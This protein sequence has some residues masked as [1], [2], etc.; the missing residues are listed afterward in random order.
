[1]KT[2]RYRRHIALVVI[3]PFLSAPAALSAQEHAI[4][5][6][7]E[8][9]LT[10][11]LS[12]E[13][14]SVSK[15]LEQIRDTA[16][17]VHVVT[18]DDIRR[19]GATSIPEA[20]RLV[21]GVN[22]SRINSNQWAV[23]IR[24]F[25]GR[26]N[27]KLL[28]LMDGRS[29][30]RPTFSGTYWEELD[31][32]LPDI[33]R[34]EVIRGPGATL[35][36]SNAVNGIINIITRSASDTYG[37][38]VSAGLGTTTSALLGV[39]HGL[40]LTEDTDARFYANYRDLDDFE[41][42]A[43]GASA[44]DGNDILSAGFRIDGRI[45]EYMDFTL[46]GDRYRFEATALDLFQFPPPVADLD[47]NGWNLLGRLNGA[48]STGADW[49]LQAYVART[50]RNEHFIQQIEDTVDL[51]FQYR[52]A[53]GERQDVVW[54]LGYRHIADE[55]Q[56]SQW[57]A[58]TPSTDNGDI[59]NAFI[60][61]EIELVPDKLKLILGTKI[62][63][64]HFTGT[65]LQPSV[66]VHWN[67]T[68]EHAFWSSISK[69]V[70]TP[71]RADRS[72]TASNPFSPIGVSGNST[73]ENEELMA[74]ELGY[75]FSPDSN[76]SIDVA[77]F[78]N[79]YDKL[80]STEPQLPGFDVQFANLREGRGAGGEI[81]VEWKP[82]DDLRIRMGYAYLDLD[83][84]HTAG[85]LLYG[86]GTDPT[87]SEGTPE[88]TAS[89]QLSYDID[90]QWGWDVWTLYTS[91]IGRPGLVTGT[92][93][94][95]A[96]LSLN[97]RVSWRLQPGLELSLTGENLLESRHVEYV[98]EYFTPRTEI[99]RSFMLQMRWDVE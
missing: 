20:L 35:W 30:Y 70:R 39:R 83:I 98:G 50:D 38:S 26:F 41:L 34:I 71:S 60:Q 9:S 2:F 56:Q 53:W 28:V 52:F 54:G 42:T 21:P 68:A 66:R 17:A 55:F 80:W 59:F 84:N 8:M 74:Y 58:M 75:R 19:I 43:N 76:L 92:P 77:L 31:T 48:T 85:S 82:A 13:V 45:D 11:L 23:G 57:I 86:G 24:G 15:K 65:S 99:P 10:D 44:K 64:H 62:E 16:A 33:E 95:D 72:V 96:Y 47:A 63:D 12:I 90:E 87:D 49:S 29:V 89:L 61:D 91:E 40:K 36:G 51:D 6:M 3:I 81:F 1:M 69:A 97:T 37:T 14:T 79:D 46:Q 78:Y 7:L 22:V 4:D 18:A 88:H 5:R 93:P 27:S 94:I 25:T 32:Y 67:A 73:Q